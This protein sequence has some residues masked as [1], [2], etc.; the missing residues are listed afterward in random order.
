MRKKRE[1]DKGELAEIE[2]LYD[3]RYSSVKELAKIFNTSTCTMRWI[4][5]HKN[6]RQE[7]TSRGKEWMKEHP[8]RTREIQRKAC[9]TYWLKTKKNQKKKKPL[10]PKIKQKKTSLFKKIFSWNATKDSNILTFYH[11]TDRYGLR[12]TEEQGFLLR[13][14]AIDTPYTYL[15]TDIKEAKK[16]GNIIIEVQYDTNKHPEMNNY[17]KGDWQCRVYE[18]IYNYKVNS[19]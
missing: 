10:V 2:E 6:F 9:M 19:K 15:T 16:Y 14:G 1:I 17:Q 12:E 18:P 11:G 13:K 5:N 8:E 4:T 3:G 7:Q